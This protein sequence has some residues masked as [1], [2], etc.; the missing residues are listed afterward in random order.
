MGSW[1]A[2]VVIVNVRACSDAFDGRFREGVYT[3]V[4]DV[5][6]CESEFCCHCTLCGCSLVY[7]VWVVSMMNAF[8]LSLVS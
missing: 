4:G 3:L 1:L 8:R 7:K 2:S 6:G 5:G